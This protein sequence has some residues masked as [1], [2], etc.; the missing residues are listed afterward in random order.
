MAKI[1]ID[2]QRLEFLIRGDEPKGLNEELFILSYKSGLSGELL[3]NAVLQV[4]GQFEDYDQNE[5]NHFMVGYCLGQKTYF[6][7]EEQM[8]KEANINNKSFH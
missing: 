7:S 3:M 8:L 6:E 5:I 4:S 2:L 1:K